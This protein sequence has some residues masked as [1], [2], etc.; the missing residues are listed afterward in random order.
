MQ[1]TPGEK[2][3]PYEVFEPIGKGGMGV[4]YRAYDRELC[5]Q[6]GE[7][8]KLFWALLGLYSFHFARA[9]HETARELAEQCLSPH[10]TEVSGA[11]VV[12]LS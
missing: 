7:T 4:V 9:E 5:R 12:L 8:P 2:L 1:L 11:G 10:G 6:V 3:G